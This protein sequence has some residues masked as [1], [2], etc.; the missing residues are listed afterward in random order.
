M[1]A[2]PED[3]L[4]HSGPTWHGTALGWHTSL[5]NKVTKL[6]FTSSRF[7]GIKIEIKGI[8]IL[9]FTAYL[10]TAG[11]DSDY[12][13]EISLLIHNI[14]ENISPSCSIIIGMDANVSENSSDRRK[15]AF[16]K[17]KTMFNLET[18]LPDMTPTFHHNNG[19][20]ETQIDH[21]LCNNPLLLTFSEQN[22]KKDHFENLSSHDVL[23]A[24]LHGIDADPPI[25]AEHLV[26]EEFLPRKIIWEQNDY[27]EEMTAEVV[28]SLMTKFDLP[29]HLPS[30]AE[31]ISNSI[32]IC[33]KKCFQS[34]GVRKP[35]KRK[36]PAFSSNLRNAY[37]Q[38]KTI[39]KQ[40]RLA[41][42]PNSPHHPAKAAKI[43][44]QSYLQKVRKLEEQRSHELLHT[45]LMNTYRTDITQIYSK[46]KQFR[47]ESDKDNEI[48]EIVTLN[49]TFKGSE[50]LE[51]FRT[52]TEFLCSKKYDKNFHEDFLD[53]CNNDL[54]IIN[55]LISN[56]PKMIPPITIEKTNQIIQ[57]VLKNKKACDIY[58]L[59]P[60]H[61]KFAG[62]QTINLICD[63]INRVL[64]N[65]EYYSLPEFKLS[66]ATVIYK[67]KDKP[68]NNH[69]SYR[70]V[71][72]GPLL[73]RIID[74]YIRPLALR[75]SDSNH[76]KNQYGFTQ[77]VNYL[78]GALQRHETQ[79]F[80]VDNKL[81]FFGCSLDGDSAFEVVDRQIQLRELYLA[82]ETDQFSRYNISSYENTQTRIK[83]NHKISL[84]LSETLGVGQG[85]I[86]SSDHYKVYI[87]PILNTL[88]NASLGINI[89][90]I[91][92]GFCCVADDLYV[93][94][95]EPTK[96][97][98]QLDLCQDYGMKY[99]ITYGASKTVVSVIGSKADAKFY[100]E[101]KPWT[102]DNQLVSVKEDNEHLGLVI[103][104]TKEEEKNIDLKLKKCRGA[105]FKLL[106]P[107]FSVKCPLSPMLKL[108]LFRTYILP[109]ARSGLSAMTLSSKHLHCLTIFH[110]KV[111]KGFLGLSNRA[112]VP[113]L[114]FLTGELPFEGSLHRDVFSLF[115]NVWCN[116]QMKIFE[117]VQYLLHNSPKNSHTWARHIRN[118]AKTYDINDPVNIIDTLPPS[119]KQYSDYIRTKITVKFEKQLRGNAAVNSNMQF[120]NVNLK[121]L[122]GRPHCSLFHIN[123]P[124][125]SIKARSHIK[126]LCGDV[127]TFEKRD[128]YQGGG[129][130]CRLCSNQEIEN[131]I[132]IVSK[133]LAYSELRTR[134]IK[135]MKV[136]CDTAI[137]V[138]NLDEI[139]QNDVMKTQFILDCTSINL[140]FR[141]NA[142]SDLFRTILRLSRDL[143]FGITKLRTEKLKAVAVSSD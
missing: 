117:I 134:I 140:P 98:C 97:Q 14:E 96:L 26:Y 60:E 74:E 51:G 73:G 106:G 57:T 136:A 70:L 34:K 133:C 93:M 142:D 71:R 79:K 120:L 83:M 59:T 135:E 21:I 112:P 116:S 46:L 38:H 45:D 84:P 110:R 92:V 114:Y 132:H 103:S 91:N 107:T 20:S 128:K 36:S 48:T 85:K 123:S 115:H 111:I 131:T 10:P 4:S 94:S 52:N 29:E 43:Q 11:Q 138:F 7:C 33:A 64:I 100:S 137:P 127:Y 99:R 35:K 50:V 122:D 88:E 101:T 13:E 130:L 102:M 54:I 104:N 78:L 44:S 86:R 72:V 141:I 23:K 15:K 31:M 25:E 77:N 139:V 42:R 55:D 108:H 27:Y 80:C 66:I 53:Q 76:S 121:G 119:K 87:T 49:G 89:G 18:I 32:A 16:G 19:I 82:G 63:F 56:E 3:I 90:P 126:F 8:D 40:W 61:L 95:D 12:L 124:G 24:T 28:K 81:T 2:N 5:T 58:Q 67:G 69:K 143:C 62:Q 22:C 39:C 37:Q 113:A 75:L 118:L 9:A 1:F 17:L 30:L 65:L 105:L 41:G 129:D 47:N 6:K 109:I 125:D 68:K